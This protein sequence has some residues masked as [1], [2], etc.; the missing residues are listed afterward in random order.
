MTEYLD[1]MEEALAAQDLEAGDPVVT[2]RAP[3]YLRWLHTLTFG[4]FGAKLIARE[5]EPAMD[6]EI[7]HS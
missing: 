5:W 3:W 2:E 4:Y 7:H 1:D 6:E